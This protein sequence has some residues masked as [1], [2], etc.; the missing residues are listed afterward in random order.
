MPEQPSGTITFLFS[1]IEGSTRLWERNPEAMRAALLR[2][3]AIV[4]Q[5]IERNGGYVYEAAGDAIHAVF[6]TAPPAA[7]A[8]IEVQ[9][10]LYAEEWPAQIVV[11]L[12]RVAL[13]SGEVEGRESEY[14]GPVV[15]RVERLLAAGHGGQILTSQAVIELLSAR[16]ELPPDV[17]IDDLG[18]HRLKDLTRPE[19]IFQLIAPD[20]PSEFPPLDT[21]EGTPNNLP[22]QPTPFIGRKRKVDAVVKMLAREDVRLLTLT[23]PGG[24]GKTRLALQVAAEL[25][26]HF[27][28]GVFF[29]SLA[30]TRDHVLVPS[31]VAEALGVR[32]T[33]GQSLLESVKEYLHEKRILLVLDNYEHLLEAAPVVWELLREAPQVK[34]LVTS[35]APLRISAEHEYPVPALSLPDTARDTGRRITAESVSQYEAVALFVARARAANSGFE[36]NNQNAPAVAEICVRLD[37]IPLA[38]ELAAARVKMLTP[39]ALLSRLGNKLK[40]LTGGARDLPERQQTLNSTIEWSHDLLDAEE[41]VLFRRMSAFRGGFTLEAAEAILDFGLE[42]EDNPKSK[43]QNPKL[44]LLDGTESLVDKSLVY[45]KEE[46]EGEARFWM[47]ETIHEYALARLE[48]SGEGEGIARQHARYFLRLAEE[49]APNLVGAQQGEWLRRLEM[50]HDNLRAAL[51]WLVDCPESEMAGQLAGA[52][53]RFWL[54]R[55]HLGEGRRWLTAALADKEALSPPVRARALHGLGVMAFEQGDYAEAEGYYT[56]ARD[57]RR[58]LGDKVGMIAS[59][60]NLANIALF[61]GDYE[62]AEGYYQDALALAREL[63]DTWAIAMTLGN[64]GWIEMNRGDYERAATYYEESLALRRESGDRWG[65]ANSLDNLA[66]ARTYQGNYEEAERLADESMVLFQ[67]LGDKDGISDLLDIKARAALDQGDH[68][69]TKALLKQSLTMNRE[70]GDKSGMA[71]CLM[72]YAATAGAEGRLERAAVLF[73]AADALRESTATYQWVYFEPHIA[74]AKAQLDEQCWTKSWQEGKGMST[75][76]VMAYAI[77]E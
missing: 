38:I 69:K 4:R 35:R 3:E 75:E 67:E 76:Q 73:G 72:G 44:D 1:D 61:R 41:K 68:S 66:W 27:G 17:R 9:R 52:L 18:E 51:R 6:E 20:L 26:G 23:G 36:V 21:L 42:A 11:L 40:L 77:E 12:A 24:I 64:V 33:G 63:E 54:R 32:E 39:D 59:T 22:L 16:Q 28:D 13:H 60:N 70:L 49:A 48:E 50:E 19:H 46:A 29:V 2:Y 25:L 62:Q 10:D 31:I 53:T 71:L 43:F 47:L 30:P 57:L 7:V 15:S 37:G 14:L 58:E 8:A 65:V 56:E 5:A 45:R 55:G 74:S 34:A